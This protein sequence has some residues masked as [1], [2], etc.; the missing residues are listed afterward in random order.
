MKKHGEAYTNGSAYFYSPTPNTGLEAMPKPQQSKI[1]GSQK[2][3][4][5]MP[6]Y[7]YPYQGDTNIQAVNEQEGA[8]LYVVTGANS[9]TLGKNLQNIQSMKKS[10]S[11]HPQVETQIME[12]RAA[13]V[14]FRHVLNFSKDHLSHWE[15]TKPALATDLPAEPKNA[16]TVIMPKTPGIALPSTLPISQLE[17]IQEHIL[18]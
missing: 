14:P 15:T 2:N 7:Y 13:S 10:V 5:K 8:P 18:Q 9:I 17:Q 11:Y 4:N 1:S 6:F 16:L 3:L 12:E